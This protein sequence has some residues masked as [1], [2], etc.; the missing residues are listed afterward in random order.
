MRCAQTGDPEIEGVREQLRECERRCADLAKASDRVCRLAQLRSGRLEFAEWLAE[1][2]RP[3]PTL[4]RDG[5]P[6]SAAD[7]DGY[8]QG[9]HQQW[10]RLGQPKVQKAPATSPVGVDAVEKDGIWNAALI[11]TVSAIG[12]TRDEAIRNAQLRASSLVQPAQSSG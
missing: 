4:L 10:T 11:L 9:D 5:V 3:T 12:R 7:Q 1:K 6:V 8:F 2:K